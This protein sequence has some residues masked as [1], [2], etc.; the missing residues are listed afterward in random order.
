MAYEERNVAED[1]AAAYE[2][3]RKT[4]QRG[5]P[6][7]LVDDEVVIGFDRPRLE[8]LLAHRG[9]GKR[10]FGL[11][12]ADASRIARSQGAVPV[13]GAFVGRVAVGSAAAGAGLQSGDIITEL[14]LRPIRNAA[15]LEQALAA[16]PPGGRASI[17]F[18][19]GAQTLRV[20]VTF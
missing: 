17:T 19:R 8:L 2:M 5:V 6:V 13:F 12:I 10:S 14:N 11:S 15:D 20:E 3:I 7:I 1:R 18:L 16:I 4:G 9:Q